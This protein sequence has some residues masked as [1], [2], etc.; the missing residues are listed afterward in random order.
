M[1]RYA[2][3]SKGGPPLDA[4][5]SLTDRET[6]DQPEHQTVADLPATNVVLNQPDTQQDLVALPPSLTSPDLTPEFNLCLDSGLSC[7]SVTGYGYRTFYIHSCFGTSREGPD[8][9]ALAT[10]TAGSPPSGGSRLH[11]VDDCP[12]LSY[13]RWMAVQPPQTQNKKA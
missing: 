7:K 6:A 12:R 11:E 3:R 5:E 9:F 10:T 1:E 8:P 13:Q 4:E 2:L